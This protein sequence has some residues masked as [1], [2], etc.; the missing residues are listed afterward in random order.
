MMVVMMILLI[1]IDFKAS[2]GYNM[3]KN[4]RKAKLIN[5]SEKK[6]SWKGETSHGIL[7]FMH[8]LPSPPHEVSVCDIFFDFHTDHIRAS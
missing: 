7:G 8:M 3:Q 6:L 4:P 2:V 5:I 1:F